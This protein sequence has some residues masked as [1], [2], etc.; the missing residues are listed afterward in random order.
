M[1]EER[2]RCPACGYDKLDEPAWI[3]PNARGGGSLE[4]CPNCKMQFGYDDAAG[5]DPERRKVIWREWVGS[6]AQREK[7][8][9]RFR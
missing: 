5:G 3:A 8:L 6:V 4:I 1:K 7:I 2:S 9:R